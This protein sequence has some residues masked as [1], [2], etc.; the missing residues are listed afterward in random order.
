MSVGDTI[1]I[2]R[3][4]RERVKYDLPDLSEWDVEQVVQAYLDEAA[5]AK[6]NQ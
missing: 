4:V 5:S 1:E 3:R 2:S 6:E